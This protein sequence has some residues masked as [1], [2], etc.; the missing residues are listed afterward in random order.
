MDEAGA[1]GEGVG[2]V[3]ESG[4]VGGSD[5]DQS[6]SAGADD[7]GHP[8]RAADLDEFATGDEDFPTN[9]EPDTGGGVDAFPTQE[10]GLEDFQAILWDLAGNIAGDVTGQ[11]T[12]DMF[13]VPLTNALNG[14][15]D[16]FTG[17][18]ACPISNTAPGVGVGVMVVCP[19]CN[20]PTRIGIVEREE[21][22]KHV[23]IRVCKRAD[24]GQEN[25]K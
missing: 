16:P 1:F 6:G 8:E 20:R 2:V 15:I 9:G 7:V 4:A 18:N 23:R 19:S 14:T 22:D 25:E 5:L 17:L 12:Y 3:G 21:H 13:N 11:M 24:C 10:A